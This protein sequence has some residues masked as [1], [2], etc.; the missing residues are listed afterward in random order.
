MKIR[1][2][3]VSNSSSCSF[4]V[5]GYKIPKDKSTVYNILTK[6]YPT[7]WEEYVLK[8]VF[9]DGKTVDMDNIPDLHEHVQ[10]FMYIST[11]F[12]IYGN[13]EDGYSSDTHM[14]VGNEIASGDDDTFDTTEY[15]IEE[16][17]VG[18]ENLIEVLDDL[19]LEYEKVIITG[20]CLC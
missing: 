3:F 6:L 19:D 4:V 1:T 7:E 11:E 13:E 12:Q 10:E 15:K 17:G 8:Y 14:V 18:M 16:F 5:L 2:G 9:K 20:T